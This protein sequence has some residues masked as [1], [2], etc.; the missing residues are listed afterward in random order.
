MRDAAGEIVGIRLAPCAGGGK[1]QVA[2]T[3]AGLFL[4]RAATRR[5][6]GMVWI[7]EG[8]S[9]PMAL[10]TLA[11]DAA[12]IGRPNNTALP[13]MT[14]T[15]VRTRRHTHAVIVID[16][17]AGKPGA[18]EQ[19]RHGAETLREA[20]TVRGV[21]AAVLELDDAPDLRAWVRAG[22]TYEALKARAKAC[23]WIGGLTPRESLR[24]REVAA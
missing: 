20:L 22:G 13:E 19:T 3:S 6:G 1:Y 2:G 11:P 10:L 7:V 23:E 14:A 15:H 16:N 21:A 4:R 24:L 5:S 12:V 18:Q 8:R 17:D 9:D